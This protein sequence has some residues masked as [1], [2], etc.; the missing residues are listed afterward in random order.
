MPAAP[1]LTAAVRL[2]AHAAFQNLV[3]FEVLEATIR[4]LMLGVPRSAQAQDGDR[5]T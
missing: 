5:S 2:G 3:S 1:L 4:R